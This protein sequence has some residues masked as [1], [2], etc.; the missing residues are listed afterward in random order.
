MGKYLDLANSILSAVGG[1]ENITYFAHCT[2]RLRFN[3]KD[4]SVV[5]VED[6]KKIKGVVGC[7]W[8]SDELQIIIGTHVEFVYDEICSVG[9]IAKTD[10]IDENLDENL[11]NQK[12]SLKR[13]GLELMNGLSG[14]ITPLIYMMAGAGLLKA[15]TMILSM[16]GVLP[17]DSST[18]TV[19]SWVADG[20]MYFMPIM[21]GATAAKRFGCDQGVGM[22][23]G[24]TLVY[25]SFVQ[26]V[27]D[28]TALTIFGLPIY[29]V[30]YTTT[31][32]PTILVIYVMSYVE[33]GLK[34]IIPNSLRGL[35]VP[36][37][38]IIVMLPV[39]LVVVA[40]LGYYVGEL[41]ATFLSWLNSTIGF[42][43]VALLATI[44]PVLVSTGMHTLLTPI[45]VSGFST[46]GYDAFFLPV[47]IASNLNVGISSLAVSIKSKNKDTKS[48]SLSN[49]VTA[50]IAGTT[51]PAMFGT[52][53]RLKKPLYGVMIG[54]AVAG[55]IMGLAHVACY[56]F[57]GS[58][59]VFAIPVF[60]GP[61]SA[62]MIWFLIAIVAGMITS[63][64]ATLFIGF[65]ENE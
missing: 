49:A 39:S 52:V 24:A 22:L 53:L 62:N 56:G 27:S 33:K 28:G 38:T 60:V 15:L 18:Y 45:W 23:L 20:F 42:V 50:C 61:T 51:E 48:T 17:S 36:F 6:I 34:K 57:P 35:L 40:P 1:K 7:Q 25:P 44:L 4:K 43:A 12:F 8:T 64:V 29:M 2:T 37:I 9:G 19:L 13:M 31:V 32:V 63:F 30:S 58:G 46:F 26:A 65:N 14:S 11:G 21:L 3:L 59:G 5:N 47:M 16:I 54:N 41:I 55:I 10:A